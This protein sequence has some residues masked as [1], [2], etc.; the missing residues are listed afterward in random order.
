MAGSAL[1][2]FYMNFL[3]WLLLYFFFEG[4]VRLC[5]AAFTETVLGTLPLFAFERFVN[6]LR[7]RNEMRPGEVLIQ[8]AKSCL[9][10]VREHLMVA[11]L[12]QVPDTLHYST[13][14]PD[15]MLEIWASRR[16][17]EWVPPRIVQVDESFYRLEELSVRKP[18]RPF[19]YRLRRLEA[20]VRG[21]SVL[22]YTDRDS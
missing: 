22:P 8:N 10:S 7:N 20:G 13:S 18:P 1:T 11:N 5:G 2:I 21:R 17:L 6:L 4:A 19:H 9:E 3:T 15:Q 16:K 14:G 12:E